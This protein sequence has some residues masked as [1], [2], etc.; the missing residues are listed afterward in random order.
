MQATM[1]MLLTSLAI[2]SASVVETG[3]AISG[4]GCFVNIHQKDKSDRQ[5]YH[6]MA[7]FADPA[8]FDGDH[9]DDM[10][11]MTKDD[12]PDEETAKYDK[13]ELEETYG[14]ATEVGVRVAGRGAYAILNFKVNIKAISVDDILRDARKEYD[15]WDSKKQSTF[16]RKNLEGKAGIDGLLKFLPFSV[17]GKYSKTEENSDES[18]TLEMN[19]TKD[20]LLRTI[21]D[22]QET[23]IEISGQLGAVG[24]SYIPVDAHAYVRILHI[25]FTNKETKEVKE[26]SVVESDKSMKALQAGDEYGPS[27]K[28]RTSRPKMKV[29]KLF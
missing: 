29:T 14:M 11:D 21:A 13:A 10:I 5:T 20:N 19:S 9:I 22:K 15:S 7:L 1:Y 23:N 3:C 6:T 27:D 28:V 18:Q 4:D 25:K 16:D 26:V 8:E 17:G 12:R 24:R 2:T